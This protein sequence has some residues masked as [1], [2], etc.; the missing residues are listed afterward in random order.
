MAPLLKLCRPTMRIISPDPNPDV[1]FVTNMCHSGSEVWHFRQS[2]NRIS[3]VSGASMERSLYRGLS[4]TLGH[5]RAASHIF[6][7]T[8]S[9]R[10]PR[11]IHGHGGETGLVVRWFV[12]GRW[13][14]RIAAMIS[15]DAPGLTVR[16][17]YAH[18]LRRVIL[19]QQARLLTA[20]VTKSA[21]MEGLSEERPRPELRDPERRRPLP[22]PTA[23]ASRL[24]SS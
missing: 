9:K 3:G 16:M 22:I 1:L 21:E 24:A 8:W 2:A 11:L 15:V 12:R 7:L 14:F 4:D 20:T 10:R 18:R 19:R 5:A 13:S 23:A 17:A 6:C